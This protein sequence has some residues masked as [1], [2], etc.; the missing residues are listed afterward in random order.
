MSYK[1]YQ[2]VGYGTAAPYYSNQTVPCTRVSSAVYQAYQS[3]RYGYGGRTKR[4]K[5]SGTGIHVVL[6]LPKWA[7]CV[8]TCTCTCTCTRTSVF[9]QDH[10]LYHE[11]LPR[12]CQT[13]KVS[14][15]GMKLVLSLPKCL[16]LLFF[17]DGTNPNQISVFFFVAFVSVATVAS[18]SGNFRLGCAALCVG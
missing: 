11:V 1:A 12:A 15:M 3:V 8:C 5:V 6:S 18:F 13:C 17:Y 7:G 10:T 14:D 2:S 4:T 9:E 16:L